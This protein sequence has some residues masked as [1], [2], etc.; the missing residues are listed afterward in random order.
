MLL[1]DISRRFRHPCAVDLKM[2]TRGFG[3]RETQE[4]KKR[5]QRKADQTTALSLGVRLSGMQVYLQIFYVL[6]F[7]LNVSVLFWVSLYLSLYVYV[8]VQLF[9]NSTFFDWS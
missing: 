8:I 9:Q 6:L 5:K 2:G 3:D 1:E 4:K 7:V